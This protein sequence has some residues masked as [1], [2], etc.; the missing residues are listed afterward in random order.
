LG[1]CDDDE[2]ALSTGLNT[3]GGRPCWLDCYF[4]A[5][6]GPGND[7]CEWSHQCDPLSLPPDYPP[8]GEARCAYGVQEQ[9][10]P[11]DCDALVVQ[12][13]SC[14]AACLPIVPNGCDCFG[15][16]EL[17]ARSGDYHFIGRGR[18]AA[19]CELSALD[20]PAACPPCTPVPS[21]FNACEPCEVCVGAGQDPA[22]STLPACA[23]GAACDPSAPCGVG[24]Y[25]VTGCCVQAPVPR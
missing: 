10:K 21:C 24:E 12:P 22:C 11:L 19:G 3:G 18:G 2:T 15:C 6:A 1:P 20:D 9:G 16:C 4:D 14:V 13:E 23:Q 5:D 8:S 17:P 7:K 25:C